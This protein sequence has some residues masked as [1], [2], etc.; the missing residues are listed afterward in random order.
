[1]GFDSSHVFPG[2]LKGEDFWPNMDVYSI[3]AHIIPIIQGL[4]HI[5]KLMNKQV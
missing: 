2:Q 1:M 3:D 4:I 5:S